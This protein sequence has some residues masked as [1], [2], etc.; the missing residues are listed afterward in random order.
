MSRSAI[1]DLV[2]TRMPKGTHSTPWDMGRFLYR[3]GAAIHRR[4]GPKGQEIPELRTPLRERVPLISKVFNAVDGMIDRGSAPSTI[5]GHL[6][7]FASF[8]R[9]VDAQE[10]FVLDELNARRQ[11]R[12]W[13]EHLVHRY[14]VLK[15]IKH[16]SAYVVAVRVASLLGYALDPATPEPGRSLLKGTRLK[17][18]LRRR[19]VSGRQSDK[20]NLSATFVFGHLMA[21]VCNALTV[22]AIRGALPL[23]VERGESP[24]V[25]LKGMLKDV[26]LDPE[27]CPNSHE[28]ERARAARAPLSPEVKSYVARPT[29]VNVRIEAELLIFIAQTGMNLSQAA[30][31]KREHYRWQSDGDELNA[32]RVHKKRRGGEAIFRCFKAYREHFQR[33]QGWLDDIGLS[34]SDDRFFP[35]LYHTGKAPAEHANPQF[36]ATKYLCDSVGVKHFGPRALRKTRVNW[37]LRRSRNPD[38]TAE[39]AAHSKETLLRDYEEPH[40]QSAA[41]EVVRFHRETDPTLVPPGPGACVDEMRTPRAVIGSPPEAPQPDC[42]SSEGCLFCVHHRDVLSDD[43]CWRLASHRHLKLLELSLYKPSSEA[44]NHPAQVVVDRIQSKLIEL[45]K[46]SAIRGLWV[47]KANDAIRSG[48]YHPMW[49][50][51]I[52]LMEQMYA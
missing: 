9:W 6:E 27:S 19:K 52:Q 37:L 39:Q 34:E 21:E 51:H 24:S 13:A 12:S 20:Q 26:H 30:R 43:Y 14:Q 17:R 47:R 29:I 40:Y 5:E 1:P 11:F 16:A 44:A 31:L 33:Y 22:D 42:V 18:P 7:A 15:A 28:R 10:F 8:I 41:A 36:Q 45:A 25:V 46:G 49:D 35:F 2:L 32:F 50:G 23:V 38:L 3:G 4:L 48:I